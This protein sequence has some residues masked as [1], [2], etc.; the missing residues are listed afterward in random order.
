VAISATGLVASS[1]R[2]FGDTPR[3]TINVD[4]DG[5]A[6]PAKWP[7]RPTTFLPGFVEAMRRFR[8][9]GH[10]VQIWAARI[11]PK[12]PWTG[13]RRPDADIATEIAY[14]RDTLDDAGLKFV[15]IHTAE[16]KPGGAVYIDD[17]AERYNGSVNSW[18]KLVDKILLRLDNE[19]PIFPH[20]PEVS[21]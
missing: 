5:T 7:E 10:P 4:W 18:T 8:D 6:V 3:H 13:E 14:I 9:A 15:G 2:V 12:D 16:G 17:K 19:A 21:P 11:N 1:P 20:I